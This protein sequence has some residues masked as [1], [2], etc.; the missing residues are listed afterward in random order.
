MLLL[1]AAAWFQW[2]RPTT[3]GGRESYV[4]VQGHSM[5]GTYQDG[6]LVIVREEGEYEVGDIIAFRAGGQFDDPT[7]IIHRIVGRADA[8]RFITRGDNRDRNDP[9]QPTDDDIIGR[10]VLHVPHVGGL[11]QSAARPQVLGALG[12]AAV[13]LGGR[14]RR[15]RRRMILR[16]DPPQGP[17][18]PRPARPPV[19]SGPPRWLRH[20]EPRWAFVGLAGCLI[21]LLPLLVVTWA[22]INAADRTVRVERFG[23]LDYSV[24]VDYRFVG[25]PSPV[26]PTGVVEIASNPAGALVPAAPLYSRL[27]DR[28]EM[29]ITFEAA[30]TGADALASTLAVD[31]TLST[32][33]GWSDVVQT[34]EATPFDGRAARAITVDL[35]DARNRVAQVTELTGVGGDEFTL[36]V[37]PRLAVEGSGGG[38]SVQKVLEPPVAFVVQ[39][40]LITADAV[41]DVRETAPLAREI[42]QRAKYGLGPLSLSTQATRGLLGGLLLVALGAGGWFASVLFGGV[43]LGEP[44]RIAARYRSQVV[45]VAGATAPP[46]PVVMVSGIDELARLAK[47]DQS[48]ILHE[49]LGDGGHRYRVFLGAVTYEYETAPEH[50]GRAADA[51]A[52][53]TVERP[54]S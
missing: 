26:Y 19:P 48:V 17:E 37:L 3:L 50:G 11:A 51:P 5:D 36:T 12:G 35:V 6:D 4:V 27:L 28:L 29:A 30:E 43:G 18:P 24:G 53:S 7:R 44:A 46:G 45:D 15:R 32:A 38:Q 47:V 2:L 42:D 31:V 14:T 25:A 13:V 1:L 21:A 34:V 33:G 8:E 22:A 20:T 10:A 16:P 41:R 52:D 54:G 49:D 9:W 23:Q 40:G 39:G